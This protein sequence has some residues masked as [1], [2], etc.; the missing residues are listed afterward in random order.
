MLFGVPKARKRG[1][2]MI[3]FRSVNYSHFQIKRQAFFVGHPVD[4][5]KYVSVETSFH[6][7]FKKYNSQ[8]PWGYWQNFILNMVCFTQLGPFLNSIGTNWERINVCHDLRAMQ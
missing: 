7:L 5:Q 8:T 4:R 1:N 3:F 6:K 2:G